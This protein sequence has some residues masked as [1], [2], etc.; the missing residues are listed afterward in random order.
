MQTIGVVFILKAVLFLIFRFPL[1]PL[2]IPLIPH[3]T[4]QFTGQR[5]EEVF[6]GPW[7]EEVRPFLYREVG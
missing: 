2:E 4:E 3:K 7:K 1:I 6:L 5:A